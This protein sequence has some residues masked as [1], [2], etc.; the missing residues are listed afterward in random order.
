MNAGKENDGKKKP[1]RKSLRFQLLFRSLAVLAVLLILIGYLQYILMKDFSYRN[2]A[3]TMRSQIIGAS[4]DLFPQLG[5]L[6][7]G[8]GSDSRPERERRPLLLP[9]DVSVVF[10]DKNGKATVLSEG[11]SGLAV[12]S[13]DNE[14]YLVA[15]NQARDGKNLY[16]IVQ[17]SDGSEQIVVLDPVG[18]RG[19]VNGVLQI[20]ASTEPVKAGL[21]RQL[22]TYACLSALAL[23]IGL[24]VYLPVIRKALVPLS[25]M[26]NTAERID[27]GNLNER[28]PVD[29]GQWEIDRL[30]YSFNGMLT[31]LEQSFLAEQEA[32]E[33][34]RRFAADASHEL[35]TPL[36][37]IHG[38]LEVL[39]RGAANRPDQLKS[40]LESMYGESKR[41]NKLVED[42]L[43]LTKLDRAPEL[44]IREGDVGSLISEMQPQLKILA[45]NR[46]VALEFEDRGQ[47]L[48]RF[49]PDKIK[50][51]ILNLFYNAVQHTDAEKGQITLRLERSDKDIHLYVSDN[52]LGIPEEHLPHV[53]ERFYRSDSSRTRKQGGAGLG[54]AISKSIIEAHSGTIG[55]KSRAGVGTTFEIT[56]PNLT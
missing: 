10:I 27:A 41:I 35:R 50:Q 54:L 29:Q 15:Q 51:V 36:T 32:K 2:K 24:L 49:D 47:M 22:L 40:A 44:H 26:V 48:C 43:L 37:S 7:E 12:P 9:P 56:I 30:S 42:L 34:M 16:Q 8:N 13:L 25:K 31:R 55:V 45:G 4:R 52:G 21:F 6:M 17:A 11:R 39:I 38:F 46:T 19:K 53:F 20:S 3:E 1:G 28:F 18:P 33:Q 5:A 14:T 23:S